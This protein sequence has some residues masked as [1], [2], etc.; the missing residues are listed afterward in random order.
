MNKV[1]LVLSLLC[2]AAAPSVPASPEKANAVRDGILSRIAERLKAVDAEQVKLADA[3]S[4]EDYAGKAVGRNGRRVWTAA[5]NAAL[6]E[7]EV[8]R[9]PARAEPYW[10]DGEIRIGSRRRIEAAGGAV[11]RR[12]P[13]CE[14]AMIRNAAWENG[15]NCPLGGRPDETVAVVGGRWDA[16]G[17]RRVSHAPSVFSFSN[18]KGLVIRDLEIA[19]APEFAIQIGDAEGVRVTD[20]GFDACKADGVHVN[21]NVRFVRVAGLSGRV[22]D[23]FVALNAFDWPG[24][25]F[26]YGDI[27]HALVEDIEL[28][29]D[30]RSCAEDFCKTLRLLPGLHR[31]EDGSERLC[32]IS[33]AVVRRVN[34]LRN[35]KVYC[36]TPP[37]EISEG[38]LLRGMRP[39]R[40]DNLFFEDLTVDLDHP[41]DGLLFNVRGDRLHGRA[42]A[43]EFGAEIGDV[44]IR[45]VDIYANLPAFP[46]MSVVQVAPKHMKIGSREG[47]D[48][49]LDV[50]VARLVLEDVRI[51]G[52]RMAEPVAVFGFDDVNGDGRSSGKATLGR[53]VRTGVR[54]VGPFPDESLGGRGLGEAVLS[55]LKPGQRVG[56]IVDRIESRYRDWIKGEAQAA[57]DLKALAV[58]LSHF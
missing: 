47:G 53:L 32:C 58:E 21:G 51:H 30:I 31:Y 50:S 40:A 34:G 56:K 48:P 14:T 41:A 8:V 7:H 6:R 37:Y 39:G 5:F 49:Y 27:D 17:D 24:C 18:V 46:M 15:V 23:D 55:G 54:E 1:A 2:L 44:Y 25:S 20:V 43:W 11:I 9:I 16:G 3:V 22:G 33:N 36:Q 35:F 57:A 38:P 13:G 42:A 12:T 45:N 4:V 26:N 10:I 19:G 29:C 52:G 28:R